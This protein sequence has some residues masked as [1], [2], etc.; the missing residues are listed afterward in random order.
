M[1]STSILSLPTTKLVANDFLK[2]TG[3][4]QITW[5][6]PK[7]VDLR[8]VRGKNKRTITFDESQYCWEWF[9]DSKQLDDYYK[10]LIYYY[11]AEFDE[12]VTPFQG[13]WKEPLHPANYAIV[14]IDNTSDKWY[15]RILIETEDDIE[16]LFALAKQRISYLNKKFFDIE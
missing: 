14:A 4:K 8:K 11:P 16:L 2:K 6:T 12:Y 1:T 15:E 7:K 10:T 13:D 3:F 9:D 5:G